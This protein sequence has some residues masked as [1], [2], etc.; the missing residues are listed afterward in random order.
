MITRLWHHLCRKANLHLVEGWIYDM[1]DNIK[2]IR[3]D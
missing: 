2:E 3:R 1:S